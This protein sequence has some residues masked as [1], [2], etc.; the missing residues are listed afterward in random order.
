MGCAATGPVGLAVAVAVISPSPALR[1]GPARQTPLPFGR[2]GSHPNAQRAF[3]SSPQGV[4]LSHRRARRYAPTTGGRTMTTAAYD[5][6]TFLDNSFLIMEGANTPMH[7]AGT[8]TYESGPARHARRR[9]RHRPHPRLR[10]VAAPPHPALP[11]APRP[12]PAR[13][14]SGVGRRR[15]LQHPLPRAPHRAAP[16]RRRAAAE[17]PRGA[18]H[19]AASRSLEAALGDVG[20]RGPRRRRDASRSSARSTTAWSTACRASIS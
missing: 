6:L 10:R 12:R 7:V 3:G 19:V 17:A 14:A 4:G 8:A 15:P 16:S 18:H 11:P 20:G 9:H 2:V 13:G 1:A 5:R